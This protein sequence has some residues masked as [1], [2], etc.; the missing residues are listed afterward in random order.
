MSVPPNGTWAAS[1]QPRGWCWQVIVAPPRDG[2][3]I[4]TIPQMADSVWGSTSAAVARVTTIRLRHSAAVR[5]THWITT[6]SFLALL[7]TGVEILIS[8]PRFYWGEV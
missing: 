4:G 7:V 3:R 2:A 5:V 6:L 8:H 1:F